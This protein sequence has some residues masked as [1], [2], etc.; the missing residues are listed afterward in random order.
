MT[1]TSQLAK[2][3]IEEGERADFTFRFASDEEL[4]QVYALFSKTLSRMDR[5]FFLESMITILRELFGNALKANAKRVFFMKHDFRL[6]DQASYDEGMKRFTVLLKEGI[7]R[8]REDLERSDLSI[9]V[10]LEKTGEGILMTVANTAPLVEVEREKVESRIQEAEKYTSFMEIY[11]RMYDKSEGAGLGIILS[12][13]LLRHSGI[14][15]SH[16]SLVSDGGTTRASVLIPFDFRPAGFTNLVKEEIAEKAAS[17]PTLPETINELLEMCRNE[18]ISIDEIAEKILQDASMAA[19][20][21]KTANSA[22]FISGRRIESIRDALMIIGIKN[23]KSLLYVTGAKRILTQRYKKFEEI[24]AHCN[25]TAFYARALARRLGLMDIAEKVTLAGLLHDLGKIVLLSTD[26]E[27]VDRISD[28][29][30][31]RKLRCTTLIEEATIGL[32]HADIGGM[33]AARWNFPPYLVEAISRHHAPLSCDPQNRDITYIAYLANMMVGIEEG[34]MYYWYLESQ[35]LERFGL[36]TD[37]AF[38]DLHDR[39]LGMYERHR[40]RSS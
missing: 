28:L 12:I 36:A 14:D 13:L 34:R 8:F 39:I 40:E 20:V 19:D 5:V 2:R 3:L 18:S 17:L 26:I 4:V 9:T 15:S 38:R 11:N 30:S 35:V 10:S 21:L 7:E 1:D 32:S 24:W 29:V 25:R 22:G 23:F 31:N 6:S 37:F 33:I 16:F 27:L